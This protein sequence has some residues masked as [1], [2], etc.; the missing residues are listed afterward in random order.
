MAKKNV[1]DSLLSMTDRIRRQNGA[2]ISMASDGVSDENQIIALIHDPKE[3][4]CLF[5]AFFSKNKELIPYALSAISVAM[6]D[7]DC[8]GDCDNCDFADECDD[9]DDDDL[10]MN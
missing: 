3:A 9:D 1:Y 6:M 4:L 8:D 2:I 10:C 5:T 7:D